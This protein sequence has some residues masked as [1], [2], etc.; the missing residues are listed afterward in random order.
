MEIIPGSI[1][2]LVE[3]ESSQVVCFTS[4]DG[5]KLVLRIR[6]N[7]KD[8]LADKYACGYFGSRVPIPQ[9]LE[10][11]PFHDDYYCITVFAEGK[12]ASS[13]DA[14]TFRS[15]LPA[16]QNVIAK[17]YTADISP[18]TGYGYIDTLTGNAPDS[19]W[20]SSL[21]GE[22]DALGVDTLRHHAQKI[23]LQD[24]VVDKLLAVF[25]KNL[26]Y[27]SETRRLLHGDPGHDNLL[28]LDDRV[29]A[30]IDWEQM[31]YGDWVRDF[32]RFQISGYADYGDI[33]A[34]AKKY[35]L[36]AENM[37]QRIAVYSTIYTFRDIEFAS[38]QDN[39]KIAKHTRDN[40]QRLPK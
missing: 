7:H 8:L 40:I 37:S 23:Y 22:L 25:E 5:R 6:D 18:T 15:V 16:I 32:S 28:I 1:T 2:P 20:R 30:V 26:P 33:R 11:G 19:S 21:L 17:V 4:R 38:S 29:S 14:H 24:D 35:D 12:T 36:E 34:F 27:I 3:G 9:F 13:L 31:A 39:E 10:S